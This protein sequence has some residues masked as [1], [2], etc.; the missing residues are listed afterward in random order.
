MDRGFHLIVKL[1]RDYSAEGDA[2]P[3]VY[4]LDGGALFPMLTG[5]YNYLHWEAVVPDLIVVGISYGTDTAPE[6]NYRSTDYTAPSPEREHYG[7][8]GRFQAVLR[9]QILPLIETRYHADPTQRVLFGQSI[10]GQFV[11]YSAMTEPSLFAGHIASNPA[12]HRNL[13]FFLNVKE[14]PK[15]GSRLLVIRGA[16]DHDRF[17]EPADKWVAYWQDQGNRLPLDMEAL[18]L[19]GYGHFSLAPESFRQGIIR[20]LLTD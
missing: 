2:Y 15:S 11:V 4:L 12:L 14:A 3:T 20:L 17:K 7:G 10:G 19:P 8:A 13:E 9:D 1:P 16:N 5:Y 6:G 18:E